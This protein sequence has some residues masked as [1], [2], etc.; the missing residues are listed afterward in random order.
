MDRYVLVLGSSPQAIN[1]GC[2]KVYIF[3]SI[4][5]FLMCLYYLYKS[6]KKSRQLDDIVSELKNY[7]GPSDMPTKEGIRA[8]GTR[9][10]LHKVPALECVIN[11][12]GAYF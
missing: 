10:V 8:C 4:D 7:L 3:S 2:F 12:F 11:R 1:Q 5:E 6:S 9:F